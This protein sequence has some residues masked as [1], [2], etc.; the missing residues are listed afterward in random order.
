MT[1]V[2]ADPK[3]EH[4]IGVLGP[5]YKGNYDLVMPAILKAID[6]AH[7]E[8]EDDKKHFVIIHDGVTSGVTGEVIETV[9]KTMTSLRALGYNVSARRLPLDVELHGKQAHYR[10]VDD[11]LTLDLA[12]LVLFDN[13]EFYP[14][15]YAEREAA[16]LDIT[17]TKT[18]IKP[19][20]KD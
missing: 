4:L 10:W 20:K 14:V 17:V 9:N 8:A 13:D 11:L 6:R 19:E 18:A 5:R 1:K 16:K 2:K 15:R 3:S 7:Y 12:L